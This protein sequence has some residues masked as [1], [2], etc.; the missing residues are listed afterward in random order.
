M[1]MARAWSKAWAEIAWSYGYQDGS[2]AACH[3][4]MNERRLHRFRK[5]ES[6]KP[7]QGGL[8]VCF[9]EFK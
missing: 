1:Q 9:K 2:V 7:A 3:T 4:P 8:S 6:R 5:A